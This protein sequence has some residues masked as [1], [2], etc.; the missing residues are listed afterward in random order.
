MSNSGQSSSAQ[1]QAHYTLGQKLLNEEAALHLCKARRPSGMLQSLLQTNPMYSL[2]TSLFGKSADTDGSTEA[3]PSE[4]IHAEDVLQRINQI[5]LIQRTLQTSTQTNPTLSDLMQQPTPTYLSPFYR[6]QGA[7]V[8]PQSRSARYGFM[9]S[10]DASLL[11]TVT[12]SPNAALLL[13]DTALELYVDHV[14]HK[15]REANDKRDSTKDNRGAFDPTDASDTSAKSPVRGRSPTRSFGRTPARPPR[16]VSPGRS[17]RERRP[18]V[19]KTHRDTYQS[20]DDARKTRSLQFEV[21]IDGSDLK[22]G[23]KSIV[24]SMTAYSDDQLPL[25]PPTEQHLKALQETL[26]PSELTPTAQ[27]EHLMHALGWKLAHQSNPYLP[28]ALQRASAYLSNHLQ[29][30]LATLGRLTG[31]NRSISQEER[32]EGEEGEEGEER[33][34]AESM[35]VTGS[36]TDGTVLWGVLLRQ[37]QVAKPSD[38]IGWI[39]LMTYKKIDTAVATLPLASIYD[40]GAFKYM[41]CNTSF[42]DAT[43]EQRPSL[44]HV[45]KAPSEILTASYIGSKSKEILSNH[46]KKEGH[47]V[48]L[49]VGWT[50]P[51]HVYSHAKDSHMTVSQTSSNNQYMPYVPYTADYTSSTNGLNQMNVVVRVK[52]NLLIPKSSGDSEV[53]VTDVSFAWPEMP[54]VTELDDSITVRSEQRQVLNAQT[55]LT[56]TKRSLEKKQTESSSPSTA[57]NF[58]RQVLRSFSEVGQPPNE[59]FNSRLFMHSQKRDALQRC[60]AEVLKANSADVSE[61]LMGCDLLALRIACCGVNPSP[62]DLKKLTNQVKAMQKYVANTSDEPSAAQIQQIVFDDDVS[63]RPLEETLQQR[64]SLGSLERAECIVAS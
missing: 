15:L 38:E 30:D 48:A 52:Y 25:D 33:D 35:L 9:L 59:F 46:A 45:A 39:L 17:S 34:A 7:I 49:Q 43:I 13:D 14:S 58:D 28:T 18:R 32:E 2:I 60:F 21:A 10:D 23:F 40:D 22:I 6:S 20:L 19:I 16:L 27:N 4:T 26:Q 24:H 62:S 44:M 61:E 53:N 12:F 54:T 11:I 31:P 1:A 47:T 29:V 36:A 63:S 55:A 64:L 3:E 50:L 57:I 56:G 37:L 41:P 42:S 8:R 5:W 51:V